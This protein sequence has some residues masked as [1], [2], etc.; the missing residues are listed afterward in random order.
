MNDQ[1]S[2]HSRR[3]EPRES[4]PFL[5]NQFLAGSLSLADPSLKF[6]LV[7]IAHTVRM[8]GD[9]IQCVAAQ[10]VWLNGFIQKRLSTCGHKNLD[11]T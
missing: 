6:C 5:K 3:T 1:G 7:E 2:V 10:P 4:I 11:A 8:N 9:D